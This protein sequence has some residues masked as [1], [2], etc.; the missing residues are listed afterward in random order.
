M[1][2]SNYFERIMDIA[3][4]VYIKILSQNFPGGIE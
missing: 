2:R 4:V 3:V 1:D